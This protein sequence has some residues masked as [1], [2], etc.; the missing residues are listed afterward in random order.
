MDAI[1][2]V[3]AAAGLAWASGLRLYAVI[4]LAGMAGRM[5]WVELPGQ[6]DALE[7]PAVL[8]AAGFMLCIEFLADKIPALDSLWD[9]LHTFIRIPAGALLA[10]WALA[11]QSAAVMLAGALLGGSLTAGTHLTKAAS[12]VAI[13]ASP[14]PVSNLLV[15]TSEDGAAIGGLWLAFTYPVLFLVLLVLLVLFMLW[16]LPRVWRFLSGLLSWVSGKQAPG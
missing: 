9:G 3:A 7:H 1:D 11:D 15:S 12:R 8:A 2:A 5:D 16:L 6:L 10:A 13:N 4:F 14:E